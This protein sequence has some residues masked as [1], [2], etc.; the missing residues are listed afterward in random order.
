M[1]LGE[2]LAVVASFS[3]FLFFIILNVTGKHK[4]IFVPNS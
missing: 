1:I 3:P 2:R 4:H